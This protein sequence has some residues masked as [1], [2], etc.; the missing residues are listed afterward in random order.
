MDKSMLERC[1][2]Q[3]SRVPIASRQLQDP[4]DRFEPHSAGIGKRWQIEAAAKGCLQGAR[5]HA[6][7]RRDSRQ[8][9]GGVNIGMN[10][11]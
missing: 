8:T 2:R 7:R 10:M 3:Q 6:G 1:V 11:V 9:M 5:A 4:V